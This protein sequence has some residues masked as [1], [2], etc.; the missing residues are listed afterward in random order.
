MP[1]QPTSNTLV[2]S[3]WETLSV[4]FR[5]SD[6]GTAKY[7]FFTINSRK[8]STSDGAPAL[9]ICPHNGASLH[10]CWPR[11]LEA[12][13][14]AQRRLKP[15]RWKL[16]LKYRQSRHQNTT[17]ESL[18]TLRCCHRLRPMPHHTGDIANKRWQ[19][20]LRKRPKA[21]SQVGEA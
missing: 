17:T 7:P 11:S 15:E 9:P 18:W 4:D 13:C 2:N 20:H 19:T 5:P 10:P 21:S 3:P 16:V 8:S 6:P 1:S 12:R 14:P